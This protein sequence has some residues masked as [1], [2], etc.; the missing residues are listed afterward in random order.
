VALLRALQR[1][2]EVDPP[3][4]AAALAADSETTLFDVFAAAVGAKRNE[5][6]E[7]DEKRQ[8]VKRF[9][10][11]VVGAVAEQE[12]ERRYTELMTDDEWPLAD[13]TKE[14][15]D[16]DF[17]TADPKG[18]PGFRVNVKAYGTRFEKSKTFVGLEPDDT[19]GVATYKVRAAFRK[20]QREA[21]PYLFAINSSEELRADVVAEALPEEVAE[22]IDTSTFFVGLKG[23]KTVEDRLVGHLLDPNGYGDSAVIRGLREA[24]VA[25]DWRVISA[26]KANHLMNEKLDARVPAV[27][28]PQFKVAANSQPNMHFSL[29]QDMIAL[30][31]LLEMLKRAGIQHVAT[32]IAYRE[33]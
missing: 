24:V 1:P 2:D 30:E 12:F 11:V 18:R 32:K 6:T 23:W 15:T 28:N 29:Q 9:A 31:E 25:A 22:I 3:L 26:I 33:I 20:S 8:K 13:Q 5:R 17:L 27:S 14:G 19:F 4:I 16:T 7:R 10:G 21:L